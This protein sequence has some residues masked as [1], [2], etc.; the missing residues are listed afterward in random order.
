MTF[1]LAEQTRV[2]LEAILLGAAG[3]LVYDLCRAVRRVTQPGTVG[4]ALADLIF[5]LSVLGALFYFAV[6]DAAAQMR[7]YV[8]IGEGLGMALYF[9][10]LSPLV[11]ALTVAALRLAAA[12]AV[13]PVRAGRRLCTMADTRLPKWTPSV[14]IFKMMKKRLP[15]W[16]R[17]G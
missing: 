17:L 3:G 13:L 2:F 16:R 5:W 1:S 15:F 9:L 10:T 11:L 8:L 14:Q 6:T 4:T 12:A 7:L